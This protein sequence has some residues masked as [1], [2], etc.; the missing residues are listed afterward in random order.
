M[1]KRQNLLGPISLF[2]ELLRIRKGALGDY[3]RVRQA[4][5]RWLERFP[6]HNNVWVGYFEDV[7]PSM[8]N[9]NNVIPLELARYVLLHPDRD[10]D[11]REHARALIAWVRATPKWPKYL[12]HGA[13]VT[14][15]QGDGS[16]FCCNKPNE[17]CESHTARLAAAEAFYYSRTRDPRYREAA[18][19][20]FNWVSYFQGLPGRAHAPYSNQW[21]FTDEF[22]DG[23]RRMM[24]AFWAVPEW[25]PDDESHL[26]GSSSPVRRISYGRGAVSYATFDADSEDV[27]RL[28]F[29]PDA[30]SAGG[31]PLPLRTAPGAAEGYSFDRA[32]HVLRIHHRHS[33]D[34]A[35]SG[36]GG[37]APPALVTFDDPHEAS[38][39]VLAGDYPAGLITWGADQWQIG[40]PAGRFGTFNLLRHGSA[41]RATFSFVSPHLLAGIDIYNPGPQATSV[42]LGCT[43]GQRISLTIGPDEL[44]RVR[45]AWEQPCLQVSIE[46]AADAPLR[47]DNLAFL[48]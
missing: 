2:D 36:P 40:A 33:P 22:T 31:R 12:V 17:C 27:L 14:T 43:A 28:D 24:D 3:R 26:L 34:I 19:R 23:P 10:P 11:W 47:F 37:H 21:W 38:G 20:S 48:P 46:F 30:I 16:N 15:E 8:G 41:P 9:M 42:T 18:Y 4:A 5:W 35:I 25:A 7:A 32:T 1:Y 13:T 29:E 45:T 39:T 6:L 44:R